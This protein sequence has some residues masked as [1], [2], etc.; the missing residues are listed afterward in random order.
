MQLIWLNLI[1]LLDLLS[2]RHFQS[3]LVEE[4]FPIFFKII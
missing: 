4:V 2:F 1:P 3:S